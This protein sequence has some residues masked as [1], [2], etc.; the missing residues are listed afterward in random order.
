M[1]HVW[2]AAT[3]FSC[4]PTLAHACLLAYHCLLAAGCIFAEMLNRVRGCITYAVDEQDGQRRP[5]YCLFPATTH[6]D[7]LVKLIQVLGPPDAAV[8][9]RIS[10]EYVTKFVLSKVGWVGAGL[11]F[12][13]DRCATCGCLGP[14]AGRAD[15][16]TSR[17]L[18]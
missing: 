3:T 13:V 15:D 16:H 14:G 12:R 11:R 7:H 9:A 1:S 4:S 10:D 18:R 2:L 5:H 17:L 8:L 6:V